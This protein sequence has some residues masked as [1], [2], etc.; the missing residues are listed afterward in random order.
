MELPT[1]FNFKDRN[2]IRL[3]FFYQMEYLVAIGNDIVLY[4]STGAVIVI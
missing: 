2:F 3:S 4:D 1:K